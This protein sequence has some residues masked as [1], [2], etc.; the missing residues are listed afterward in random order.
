M[1]VVDWGM[2]DIWV[3]DERCGVG[4]GVVDEEEEEVEKLFNPVGSMSRSFKL[5]R[6]LS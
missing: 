3:A 1:V 5:Q 4:V 6:Q 2:G